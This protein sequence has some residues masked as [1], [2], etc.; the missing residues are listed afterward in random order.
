MY[1]SLETDKNQTQDELSSDEKWDQIQNQGKRV[2]SSRTTTPAPKRRRRR[3][4]NPYKQFARFAVILL[5][6]ILLVTCLIFLIKP[7]TNNDADEVTPETSTSA[8]ALDIVIP[9][10][11]ET[12]FSFVAVGDN[13]IHSRIYNYADL[14]SGEMSDGLYDFLPCYQYVDEAIAAADVA[15]I[16]QETI[17]GGDELGISS[18]PS[19]NTPEQMADD[20]LSLGFDIV[21]GAT[22]HTLDMGLSG[23][24]N[25]C[26]MWRE[27]EDI[28]FTG[29]Y[30][31]QE[32]ADTIR[33][34]EQDGVTIALL[35][36]TYGTNGY[37]MPN[38]YCTN[39]FDEDAI[40]EDV[41]NAK[42]VSDI[43][44][45]SAHWGDEGSFTPNDLQLEYA[46]LF[47]DLEVDLVVGTHSHT[48]QPLEWI[49]GV[50]GNQTLVAYGLGN[51]I[52]TME[53]TDTQ[54]GGMLSLDFVVKGDDVSIENIEWTPLV[55]HFGDGTFS[56][57]YLSE[58]TLEM[59]SVHYVLASSCPDAI[60][61]F[62][63]KTLEVIGSEFQINF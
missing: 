6:P 28:L 44:I 47:A 36:Y 55:N 50:N 42:A 56:V 40:R 29:I 60:T 61:Y 33:V 34:M 13:L 1:D 20:L 14:N 53:T 59:N 23:I 4:R 52:S 9:E 30:D 16:N 27:Y 32:D 5:I 8:S 18:Y 15:F 49:E 26:A 46:Q 39:L 54:L 58:Y 63:E 62:T 21:N 51:F 35:S 48:I 22:N 57:R 43:V 38:D 37:T 2:R 12:T 31:S 25:T 41:A 19:F 7:F 10:V 24:E 17:I 3:R 45:V 11:E